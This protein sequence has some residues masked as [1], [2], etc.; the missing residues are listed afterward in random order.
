MR[1]VSKRRGSLLLMALMVGGATPLDAAPAAS[2]AAPPP[3]PGAALGA[4]VA[5]APAA[6]SISGCLAQVSCGSG[7]VATLAVGF[8]SPV[9]KW[10]PRLSVGSIQIGPSFRVECRI[11]EC[12]YTM[13]GLSGPVFKRTVDLGCGAYVG[14]LT[15]Y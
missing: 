6:T 14:G 11:C 5:A 12:W 8:C 3:S 15:V 2:S 7:C 10:E 9:I 1:R 4:F 13:D